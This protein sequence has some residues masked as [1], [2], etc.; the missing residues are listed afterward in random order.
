MKK[1]LIFFIS[2]F[3]LHFSIFSAATYRIENPELLEKTSENI[4]TDWDFFWGRFIPPRDKKAIPDLTVRVPSDWNNYNLP[5][6]IRKI[7][8]TGKGAGTYRLTITNLKPNQSYAFSAYRLGYTAFEIFADNRLIFR[9]GVPS[10][11]WKNTIAE[12]N[13]DKA[14]F[15]A[16]KNGCI[17]LSICISNDYYRKG[18]F[19]G[20]FTLFE[21]KAYS[22]YHTRQICSYSVFSG[23]LLM[24]VAYCILSSIL[25]KSRVNLYLA[26]LVLTI[27]SRI[28]S[29]LFP[30]L[31]AIFPDIPFELMLRIE[32]ISVFF[33]PVFTTLYCNALNRAIFKHIPAWIISL[34]GFVFCLLDFVLPISITNRMVP[35]MQGY[36]FT[37]IAIDTILFSIRIFKDRD[38]ISI[39]AISSFLVLA[40]GGIGDIL[41]IHH[42]TF[43]KG[44]H[45]ITP[46][47]V[48]FSLM[49][50][51]M[52]AFFQNKDYSK[53]IKTNASLTATNKAYYRFVPQEFLELL[54]KKD[55]TKVQLGDHKN[56][57]AGILSANIQDFI[58]LSEKLSSI[59][60]L[61]VMNIYLQKITPFIRQYKGIIEKYQGGRIIVIFPDSA[62]SAISC[63]MKM[64]EAMIELRKEFTSR[65]MPRIRIGIG[66]HYGN[67]VSG[68][69][70][71]SGHLAEI[72]VSEDISIA[73]KTEELTRLCLKP[74]LA[75]T[76]VINTADTESTNSEYGLPFIKQRLPL[77]MSSDFNQT[78]FTVYNG[79][80]ENIL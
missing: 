54:N 35:A 45:P 66:L 24:I 14:I 34:P 78:I 27:Y 42:F 56:I 59:Q 4:I 31:K 70:G 46:A 72:S 11:N 38:I 3:C 15:T 71:I 29:Y 8:K 64:Q 49:Q 36:M 19:R 28:A 13:F 41:L 76:A 52:V 62:L 68:I 9:S 18:G 43:L 77:S 79:K 16:D 58:I 65:N 20:N 26:C 60:L 22:K 7:A 10:E 37:V 39:V 53:A 55:I 40:A 47:F 61:E 80:I 63:A 21:E 25:N 74:I 6:N 23:I 69:G 48:L 51:L 17:T 33:L 2:L 1:L 12:Q 5:E 50:I 57:K 30:L 32:Y 67:I 44:T 75:T 73:M